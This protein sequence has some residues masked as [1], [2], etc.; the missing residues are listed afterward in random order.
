M[1]T[2]LNNSR[3][4]ERYLLGKMDPSERFLFEAK[5]LIDPGLRMDFQ[6]QKEAYAPDKNVSPEKAKG[7]TGEHASATVP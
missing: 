7:R 1:K 6:A 5:L 3:T 2:F 4:I